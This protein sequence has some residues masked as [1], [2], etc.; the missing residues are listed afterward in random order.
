MSNESIYIIP[1]EQITTTLSCV[2]YHDGDAKYYRS[3]IIKIDPMPNT[4]ILILKLYLVD[5]GCIVPN[6][7]YH[8]NSTNLKFLHKE[9]SILP[10]EVYDCRLVHI[11]PSP[12]SINW[13]DD[14]RQFIYNFLQDRDFTVEIV[15]YKNPFYFIYAWIE[16][17]SM[18]QL[19]VQHQFAVEFRD[20]IESRVSKLYLF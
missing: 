6:V 10:T 7:H 11:H 5:Y 8:I 13:H 16:G 17:N 3:S 1:F 12:P 14:T 9:F 20:S 19:L 15:G 2:Y 18:N 4:D